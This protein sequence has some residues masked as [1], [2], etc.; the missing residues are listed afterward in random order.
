MDEKTCRR[1][2]GPD[3]QTE[4]PAF[5]FLFWSL[6][7]ATANRR[8]RLEG[9]DIVIMLTLHDRVRVA[10]R[11]DVRSVED[12]SKHDVE[13]CRGWSPSFT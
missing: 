8:A 6:G 10:G 5:F 9:V 1:F 11:G 7:D 2:S 3:L 12:G 13:M 4:L